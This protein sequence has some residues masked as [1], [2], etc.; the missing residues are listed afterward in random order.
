MS[1]KETM[2]VGFDNRAV[3][4]HGQR[5]LLIAGEI[6]YARSPRAMWPALLDRSVECGLNCIAA[7]VFWNV[8]EPERDVYDFSGE[9]DLRYFLR[10][11]A[12]RGLHVILRCGPYCCAE[13]NYGGY[14]PYLRDER[15]VVI[16]TWNK[17]YMTRAQKYYRRLMTEVRPYFASRGGPIIL[18]QVENEYSLVAKRYG[19]DG[20]RYLA[21]MVDLAKRLGV[22]VP[23]ITCEGGAPG[24]IECMNGFGPDGDRI[25]KHRKR[26]PNAPLIWTE[27]WPAW[28][29]TWG[30]P[31]HRRDSRTIAFWILHFIGHGGSGWNYY[32]W[33]GGTNFGRTAMYL[34]TTSYEFDAPLDEPGRPSLKGVYL[35]ELHQVLHE[36]ARMLLEGKRTMKTTRSGKFQVTWQHQDRTLTLIADPKRRQAWL[37][38]SGGRMVFDTERTFQNVRLKTRFPVWKT[39]SPFQAWQSRLEPFPGRRTKAVRSRQPME[40]LK[41]THDQSDYCWYSTIIDVEHNGAQK[42]EIPGGGDFFHVYMDEELV[43]ESRPPLEEARG[44]IL[45]VTGPAKAAQP[46]THGFHHEFTFHAA[47]GK[48]RLDILAVALGLIKGDWQIDAPMNEERKGIWTPVRLNGRECQNWEMQPML[49]GELRQFPKHDGSASW[50]RRLDPARPCTWYSARLRLSTSVLKADADFRLDATSLGKGMLFIN[51]HAL[52]RYW[53]V[54]GNG[55]VPEW[56]VWQEQGLSIDPANQLSQRY[57]HLPK[58]WLKAENRLVIFEEQRR[59]PTRIRLQIR[60]QPAP[61]L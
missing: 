40:Q 61:P 15:G 26:F 2:T 34:Q 3:T 58:T 9:R 28:Y 31:H 48:H 44:S 30:Y 55:T 19:K 7:Y 35:K 24:A 21:W 49:V 4:I 42:L 11:C 10:L 1:A 27:L 6:H 18:V 33:H 25:A 46:A 39:L 57:Y 17:P 13:W 12:E 32:M 54:K 23:T 38:D 59:L 16:R 45:P 60:R 5:T 20:Q 52:G 22:D 41:L 29:D 53:Q 56:L 47:R 37:M 51:G 8:H 14:P 36:H 50:R 43:A